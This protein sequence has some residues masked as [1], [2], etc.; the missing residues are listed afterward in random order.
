MKESVLKYIKIQ[1]IAE[2]DI[3]EVVDVW[4]QASIHAHGFIPDSYWKA[5]KE[6]M[7]N[8]YIPMSETY[9]AKNGEKILGFISLM[10]DYLAALFVR[11]ELQGRGV[12][13]S[14]LN[15]TKNIRNSLKLKVFCKNEKSIE[16]YKSRGF[17]VSSESKD[18]ETE[19][20]EF[21]MQWHE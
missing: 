2:D 10:D 6:L 13:S 1:R 18:K 4:Y 9:I 12:G 17:S 5:N 15:Y 16:F 20:N 3:P 11:P 19:E 8:K 14:L 7:K 21:V